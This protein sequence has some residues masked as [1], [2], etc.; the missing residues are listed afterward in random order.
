MKKVTLFVIMFYVCGLYAQ[1]TTYN[2]P[3]SN[4]F[5]VEAD[6]TGEWSFENPAGLGM[7]IY[8]PDYFGILESG[9]V[10]FLPD[11]TTPS[12]CWLF[13]APLN[14]TAGVNYALDF[15]YMNLSPGFDANLRVA[16]GTQAASTAMNTQIVNIGT[17][18]LNEPNWDN[19]ASSH[20]VFSVPTTGIYYIGFQD[21]GSVAPNMDGGQSIEEFSVSIAS[22]I[23]SETKKDFAIYPNPATDK[24]VVEVPNQ[25]VT[26]IQIF[27]ITG[28]LVLESELSAN[29]IVDVSI[30]MSG[31]YVVKLFTESD[32]YYSKFNKQ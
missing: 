12:N 6:F 30:L 29:N 8:S 7:W 15:R 18:D 28:A 31:V 11:G 1:I 3:Y 22:G 4:N 26:K 17:Y 20:S 23:Q 14:L 5:N 24:L 19:Y 32:F 9:S 13:S 25:N 27:N 2:P 21:A 16:I 10:V